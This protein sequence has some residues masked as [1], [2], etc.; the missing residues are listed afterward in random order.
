MA[1]FWDTVLGANKK[2]GSAIEGGIKKIT[3]APAKQ[4][5]QTEQSSNP[6]AKGY[7]YVENALIGQPLKQAGNDILNPVGSMITPAINAGK[8]V[9][10]SAADDVNW[11]NSLGGRSQPTAAQTQANSTPKVPQSSGSGGG[12]G[13]AAPALSDFLNQ[14][15]QTYGSASNPSSAL[16]AA[17]Q[18]ELPAVN[19]SYTNQANQAK[20]AYTDAGN[21]IQSMYNALSNDISQTT[22]PA[23]NAAYNQTGQQLGQVGQTAQNTVNGAYGAAENS[24]ASTLKNLGISDAAANVIAQDPSG[25]LQ[26][27]QAGQVSNAANNQARAQTQNTQG[28]QSEQTFNANTATAQ[29]QMGTQYNANMQSQLATLLDQINAN[30]QQSDANLQVQLAQA[31]D[32]A[33]PSIS[34]LLN[35]G[36][37]AYQEQY[38][39]YADQQSAAAAA[40]KLADS[41]ATSNIPNSSVIAAM[42]NA[43]AKNQTSTNQNSNATDY[44]PQINAYLQYLKQ[45]QAATK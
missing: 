25:T 45:Q 14:F 4:Y 15:V 37:Q 7:G 31:A 29:K 28:K 13:T 2:A 3:S 35:E 9:G 30:Q 5:A 1:N 11:L 10:Q 23:E 40:Q 34:D 32:S 17:L 26:A 33:A 42:I 22:A 27:Q 16:S 41:E 21:R 12:G 38:G 8:A 6:L 18:A 19:A 20:T 44:T 36:T 24:M 39:T 43:D